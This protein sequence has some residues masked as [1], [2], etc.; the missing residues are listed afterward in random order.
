MQR[1]RLS[2]I[3]TLLTAAGPGGAM[4]ARADEFRAELEGGWAIQSSATSNAGGERLSLPGASTA[5]WHRASVPT[6]VVS[7]L[8]ADGTYPD[9]YVGSNLRRIPGTSYEVGQNFSNLPMPPDSPFAVPWWYRTEFS[10][11]AEAA[12]RRL[13]LR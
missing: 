11:S 7:A 3:L 2:V 10:L 8:V 4:A 9:P 1:A 5:G 13:W 6:T 12:S